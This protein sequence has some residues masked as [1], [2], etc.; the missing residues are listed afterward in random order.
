MAKKITLD[1]LQTEI[2]RI[3]DEYE[4]QVQTNLNEIT[5]RV[6]KAGTQALRNESLAKFPESKKHKKRYGNTWTSKTETNRI[7]TRVIIY[8]SMPGLPH[9][10]E[11]G[12]AKRG[13]GRVQGKV[14]IETVERQVVN[15]FEA[16]VKAKL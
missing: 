5:K 12:H 10:L 2:N 8:S 13:G 16:E 14:H 6:G 15:Q 11:Y 9:L 3:L 1:N 4:G 7:Y